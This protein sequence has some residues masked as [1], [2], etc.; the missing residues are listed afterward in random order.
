M[1]EKAVFTRS[2]SSPHCVLANQYYYCYHCVTVVFKFKVYGNC[3]NNPDV[4]LFVTN[5]HR[6]GLNLPEECEKQGRI[7]GLKSGGTNSEGE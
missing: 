2:A 7:F 3:L 5:V 4:V 6:V 1:I